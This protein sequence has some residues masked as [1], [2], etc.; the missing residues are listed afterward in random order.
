M[1]DG[2]DPV[3]VASGPD[4]G[5]RTVRG[6]TERHSARYLNQKGFDKKLRGSSDPPKM[7][8]YTKTTAKHVVQI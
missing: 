2:T 4:S 5:L 1:G 6:E 3:S 7:K 8:K